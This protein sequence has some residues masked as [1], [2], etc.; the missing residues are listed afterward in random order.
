MKLRENLPCRVL[1]AVGCL[2]VGLPAHAAE[3]QLACTLQTEHVRW[4][5]GVDGRSLGW[6]DLGDQQDYCPPSHPPVATVKKAGKYHAATA[7]ELK[8]GLLELQFGDSGVQAVLRAT[9]KPRYLLVEVVSL[10][11]DG[12]G[13]TGLRRSAADAQ[14]AAG[15]A[16]GRLCLGLEPENQG[17]RVAP[18]EQP[19]AGVLLSAVRLR[20]GQGGPDRLPAR[21]APRGDA[22]GR[23]RGRRA[24]QV[25]DR[26]SLGPRTADQPGLVPLQLRRHL[27]GQGRRLDQAGQAA[28]HDP[29]RLPRRQLLPLRRLPAESHRP[30]PTASTASRP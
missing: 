21:Q 23:D 5:I 18:A 17:P 29:D 25:A 9:A 19:T 12:A 11:G 8:D 24:A 22:G 6:I 4:T 10:V 3:P 13:G 1:L 7:A 30:I 14:G 20:G 2:S 15:R 26:R 27:R 16:V 28:G